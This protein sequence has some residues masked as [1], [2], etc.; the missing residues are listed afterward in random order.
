[1][2][3]KG[4]FIAGIGLA[5][6]AAATW[7]TEVTTTPRKI[8]P[9]RNVNVRQLDYWEEETEVAQGQLMRWGNNAY[10]VVTE[11]TTTNSPPT[12]TSG[13]ETNGT[14]ILRYISPGPRR[15]FVIQLHDVGPIWARAYAAPEI[16]DDGFL[17][18]GELALWTES[19]DGVPQGAV[20]V[21]AEAGVSQVSATEW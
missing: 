19:G 18:S 7:A 1:M 4:M 16:G 13:S 8:L 10:W 2:S 11:G 14:A 5:I 9:E 12:F 21:A 17:L 6:V 20:Y 15:G 3:I